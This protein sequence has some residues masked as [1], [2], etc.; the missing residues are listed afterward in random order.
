MINQ[1]LPYLT[2]DLFALTF[3]LSFIYRVLSGVQN[4]LI[5]RGSEG[6][7]FLPV[8][9][10]FFIPFF[11]LKYGGDFYGVRLCLISWGFLLAMSLKRNFGNP[12][13]GWGVHEFETIGMY[14]FAAGCLFFS[15]LGFLLSVYPS[16]ILHKGAVNIGSGLDFFDQRTNDPTGRTFSFFN[17][18]IRRSTNTFRLIL[19][20]IS[21]IIFFVLWI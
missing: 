4:G 2:G 11:F 10:M 15:P 7:D 21:L 19:S 13:N 16:L 9:A 20:A 1:I 18:N 12:R 17:L 8:V 14:V 3:L 5:Y 6:G